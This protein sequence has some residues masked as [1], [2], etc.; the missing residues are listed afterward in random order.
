MFIRSFTLDV[1]LILSVFVCQT[2]GGLDAAPFPLLGNII[3]DSLYT[4]TP[5]PLISA[6][7]ALNLK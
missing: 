4:F 7:P 1:L 5:F 6:G 3:T 2:T